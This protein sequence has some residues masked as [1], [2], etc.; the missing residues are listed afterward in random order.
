MR[1][2][3]VGELIRQYHKRGPQLVYEEGIADGITLTGDEQIGCAISRTVDNRL[4][5][6]TDPKKVVGKLIQIAPDLTC[7]FQI[8]NARYYREK[9]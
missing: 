8:N 7:R 2:H 6:A 4:M 9:R 1:W 3:D 5:L